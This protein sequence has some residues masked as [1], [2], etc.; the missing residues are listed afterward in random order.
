M[1]LDSIDWQLI[2]QL[3]HDGRKSFTEL[4]KTIGF[5]GLGAKKRVTKLISQNVIYPSVL[6]NTETLNLRL[7]IILLETE[8]AEAMRKTIE[9]YKNCPRV[10]NFFTTLGGYNL[11]ALVLA[12]DQDT[13]QSEAME[14][15][16]VR[17][18]KGIRRSDFYPINEVNMPLLPL[19][20]YT[21]IRDKE[22]APCG[23]NCQECQS[24]QKQKCVACPSVKYYKG[25]LK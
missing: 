19:R 1:N 18:S 14:M 7:A 25:P 21:S 17:S 22:I 6:L 23:A 9:R 4:G 8:N 5:T 3:R 12:E 16:S 2:Q 11:V 13:L 15:C 20:Q 10:L 24:F